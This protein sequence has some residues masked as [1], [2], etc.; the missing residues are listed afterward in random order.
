VTE[1]GASIYGVTGGLGAGMPR[2]AGAFVR[3]MGAVGRND[4]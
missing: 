2:S 1:N 3:P 4:G